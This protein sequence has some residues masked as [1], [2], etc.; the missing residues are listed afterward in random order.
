MEVGVDVFDLEDL[1]VGAEVVL[2]G[3]VL[4]LT[5]AFDG[6]A[7]VLPRLHGNLL[8]VD[9]AVRQVQV[10]FDAALA[11]AAREVLGGGVRDVVGV[12]LDDVVDLQ[13]LKRDRKLVADPGFDNLE[14][15]DLLN[16][17][18]VFHFVLLV[19]FGNFLRELDLELEFL[20]AV[21]GLPN[22]QL[23][24]LAERVPHLESRHRLGFRLHVRLVH[25]LP[26]QQ[27]L[28]FVELVLLVQI[29]DEH[30]QLQ[31]LLV[32]FNLRQILL[33][34]LEVHHFPSLKFLFEV[35]LVLL[36]DDSGH[37]LLLSRIG[38]QLVE[39]EALG[40]LI[41]GLEYAVHFFD[42]LAQFLD[43]VQVTF[44]LFLEVS[45][46]LG[47][48]N[49]FG[50]SFFQG[51]LSNQNTQYPVDFRTSFYF[52]KALSRKDVF[53]RLLQFVGVSSFGHSM[54]PRLL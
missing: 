36:F 25:L 28:L 47:V 43:V 30:F 44:C 50:H 32:N 38:L 7:L 53:Q 19:D 54:N 41:F 11:L 10:G 5:A 26:P 3:S 33:Q 22:L 9:P 51:L 42:L 8:G 40:L 48:A 52:S 49:E 2:E 18:V 6:V 17:L 29:L 16:Q 21:H 4:A 23:E 20:D 12:G 34:N 1:R 45:L 46:L 24:Y 13:L 27:D 14:P 15:E 31:L 37:E 35:V 39:A